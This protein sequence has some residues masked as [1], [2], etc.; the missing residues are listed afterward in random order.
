M[1]DSSLRTSI[2]SHGQ[3]LTR[4]GHRRP[5]GARVRRHRPVWS[6]HPCSA[7]AATGR[8][9]RTNPVPRPTR[10]RAG[11]GRRPAGPDDAGREDRPDDPDRGQPDRRQLQLRPGA[12]EPDV[13]ARRARHRRRRLDPVRRRLTAHRGHQRRR[14][15]AGLGDRDQL[16]RQVLHRP[17]PA[18]HPGHLRRGRRARA[19]QR[20]RRHDVPGGD[21][22]GRHLRPGAGAGRPQVSA[23]KAALATNVRWALRP[24]RRRRPGH[25]LGAVQRVLRR[26]P[27]AGRR[28]GGGRCHRYAGQRPGRRD[29]EAL[30]RLRRGQHR[31]GPHGRGHVDP[32]VRRTSSCPRTRRVWPR[33]ARP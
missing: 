24:D 13:R 14:Q 23:G 29:R 16:D 15:P 30:R 20:A 5:R 8:W 6:R 19:Q 26:G 21:R 9:P 7:S 2:E 27:D 18:A 32:L 33:A 1:T 17:Q 25:P 11:T 31:P 10:A 3:A 28:H 4:S 12:A 22:H